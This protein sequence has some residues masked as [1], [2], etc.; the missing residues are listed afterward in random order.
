MH[1][2]LNDFLNEDINYTEMMEI[3][4]DDMVCLRL[5]EPHSIHIARD[6]LSKMFKDNEEK[7]NNVIEIINLQNELDSYWNKSER[8]KYTN[9]EYLN[10]KS[11]HDVSL[12]KDKWLRIKENTIKDTVTEEFEILGDHPKY[13]MT[14]HHVD[15]WYDKNTKSWVIELQS[16]DDYQIGDAIYIGSGK[17]DA[18]KRKDGLEKE[19]KLGKYEETE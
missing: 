19:H 1:R 4:K 9:L 14:P 12:I 5:T 2:K 3:I 8:P 13:D 17:K 16:V 15:M 6:I 18:V 10:R 7:Y 11:A